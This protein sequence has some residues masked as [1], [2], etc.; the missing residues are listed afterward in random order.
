MRPAGQEA[1]ESVLEHGASIPRLH[2]RAAFLVDG[3][4]AGL[5]LVD[6]CQF[7][8]HRTP[9]G[10][11]VRRVFLQAGYQQRR[12]I[13]RDVALA[14]PPEPIHPWELRQALPAGAPPP[15]ADDAEITDEDEEDD[16]HE[17][18]EHPE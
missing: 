7:I 14:N 2:L 5:L 18:E 3:G 4:P 17:D 15:D 13:A 9:I 10:G 16:E 1:G 6:S 12:Q 8:D 11:T